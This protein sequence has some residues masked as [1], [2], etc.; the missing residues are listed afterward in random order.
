MENGMAGCVGIAPDQVLHISVRRRIAQA[1]P[2]TVRKAGSVGRGAEVGKGGNWM[3]VF[4]G[5]DRYLIHRDLQSS[6]V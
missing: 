4:G 2:R 5:T 3:D 1:R 6:G